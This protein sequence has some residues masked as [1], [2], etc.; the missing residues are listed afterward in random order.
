[1]TP[2]IRAQSLQEGS[3]GKARRAAQTGERPEEAKEEVLFSA[4]KNFFSGSREWRWRARLLRAAGGA[5]ALRRCPGLRSKPRPSSGST[6]KAAMSTNRGAFARKKRQMLATVKGRLGASC[7]ALITGEREI[8]RNPMVKAQARIKAAL[9]ASCGLLAIMVMDVS[10]I[11]RPAGQ[12]PTLLREV[13]SGA[14]GRRG[15]RFLLLAS[16]LQASRKKHLSSEFSW[17]HDPSENSRPTWSS[18]ATPRP[19]HGYCPWM[20]CRWFR[21]LSSVGLV[22]LYC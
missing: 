9:R 3:S 16:G 6:A 15:S 13:V 18:S 14:A 12:G 5:I 19:G 22:C 21:F 20:R 7:P 4:F 17:R 11:G 8:S 1:M 10:G 2:E